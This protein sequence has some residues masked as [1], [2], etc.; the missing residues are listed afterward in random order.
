MYYQDRRLIMPDTFAKQTE[1]FMHQEDSIEAFFAN[2]VSFTKNQKDSIKKNDLFNT[3]MDYCKESSARCQPRSTLFQRLNHKKVQTSTLHGYP[4]YRGI[5]LLDTS[6]VDDALEHGIDKSEQAVKM[7]NLDIN[8]QIKHCEEQLKMLYKQQ[9]EQ[10]DS[11]FKPSQNQKHKI[12]KRI[13]A[14]STVENTFI[15]TANDEAD[16]FDFDKYFQ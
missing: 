2:R 3:Y 15:T 9:I 6:E 13:I 10:Y 12:V 4:V 11:Q 14:A 1:A 16:D 8:E 7:Q 5:K